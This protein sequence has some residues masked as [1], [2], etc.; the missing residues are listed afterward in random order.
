MYLSESLKISISLPVATV[1]R[2]R[3]ISGFVKA[4]QDVD[5]FQT[6]Q[7]LMSNFTV[8]Q[9]EL[10]QMDAEYVTTLKRTRTIAVPENNKFVVQVSF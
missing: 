3:Q 1:Y 8:S 6:K 2:H 5:F 10:L 9:P 4:V 7:K